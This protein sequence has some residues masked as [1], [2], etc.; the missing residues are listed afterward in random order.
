MVPYWSLKGRSSKETL[1]PRLRQYWGMRAR[2]ECS[3]FGVFSKNTHRRNVIGIW[4]SLLVE[5][6]EGREEMVGCN[7][8]VSEQ[9]AAEFISPLVPSRSSV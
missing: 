1:D 3:K 5:E 6:R 2:P 4:T 9:E 8:I 7:G